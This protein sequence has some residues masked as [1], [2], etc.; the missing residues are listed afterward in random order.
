[1]QLHS[2]KC[3]CVCVC[4]WNIGYQHAARG[5]FLPFP[6]SGEGYPRV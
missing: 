4:V 5:R 2:T 1:M 3:E 6:S